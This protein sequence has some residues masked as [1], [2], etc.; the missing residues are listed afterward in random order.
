[1]PNIVTRVRR[2]NVLY[3]I[4]IVCYIGASFAINGFDLWEYLPERASLIMGQILVGVP[5]A[6]YCLVFRERPFDERFRKKLR[7]PAALLLILLGLASIP[8]AWFINAVTMLFTPNYVAGTMMEAPEVISFWEMMTFIAVIPA[9]VEELIFRGIFYNAYSRVNP[10]RGILLSGFLFGLMHLNP[11][12][13]AYA[14]PLGML[15]ALVLEMTGSFLAPMLV[16]FTINGFNTGLAWLAI[17][18]LNDVG[19]AQA[20]PETEA[21]AEVAFG[22]EGPGASGGGRR[23]CEAEAGECVFVAGGWDRG[24]VYADFDCLA[25]RA[26]KNLI[27]FHSFPVHGSVNREILYVKENH[28]KTGI[29]KNKKITKNKIL[30]KKSENIIEKSKK[31]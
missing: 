8:L 23:F 16:H 13:I 22:R 14:V 31:R 24:D 19:F 1:M 6:C 30:L 4:L 29:S 11:N 5:A 20:L 15:L 7:L 18:Y 3:L 26:H 27:V 28:V 10:V 25:R 9:A 21:A 2:V 12:Q 17:R